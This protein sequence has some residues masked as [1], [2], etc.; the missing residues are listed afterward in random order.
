[1]KLEHI[2]DNFAL[3]FA[4]E[5]TYFSYVRISLSTSA[6]GFQKPF[7]FESLIQNSVWKNG[8]VF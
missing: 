4:Q 8:S 7:C 3:T 1:M 2:K 6:L 5:S